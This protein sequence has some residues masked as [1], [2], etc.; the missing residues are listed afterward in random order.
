MNQQ[1]KSPS[2]EN[3]KDAES[4]TKVTSRE[5]HSKKT[6]VT[7]TAPNKPKS[8]NSFEVLATHD[9]QEG[10]QA[11]PSVSYMLPKTTTSKLNPST[12]DLVKTDSLTSSSNADIDKAIV[13]KDSQMEIDGTLALISHQDTGKAE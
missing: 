10:H 7:S 11:H 6:P 9:T 8:S 13:L 2:P 5:K 3:G 12:S 4:F 1:S